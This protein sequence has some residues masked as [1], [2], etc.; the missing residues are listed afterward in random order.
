MMILVPSC[1]LALA[2]LGFP[3]MRAT[4]CRIRTVQR[5]AL[6]EEKLRNNRSARESR[7]NARMRGRLGRG[8]RRVVDNPLD[9]EEL[10]CASKNPDL[11]KL[12]GCSCCLAIAIDVG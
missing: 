12:A 2:L 10:Q 7:M 6:H 1:K 11:H 4:S 3:F 9:R 5:H 8:L